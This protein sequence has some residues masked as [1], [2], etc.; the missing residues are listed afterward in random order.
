MALSYGS[1]VSSVDVTGLDDVLSNIKAFGDLVTV[2][3]AQSVAAIVTDLLAN[4]QP[5]VPV[6]TGELRESGT[7]SIQAGRHRTMIIATGNA[8][9]GVDSQIS[10]INKASIS[11]SRQITGEVSYAKMVGSF[12][13]AIYTHEDLSPYTGEPGTRDNPRARTPGT[14]PKYLDIAWRER[15]N[16]YT[17]LLDEALSNKVLSEDVALVSRIK[18]RKTGKHTVDETEIVQSKIDKSGYFGGANRMFYKNP[19]KG[20]KKK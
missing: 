4:A 9:G 2:K 11:H 8:D 17:Q 7:A 12:D 18:K 15:Q 3:V 20:S 5:R 14:G 19:F 6:D 13:V 1:G 16:Y 10:G